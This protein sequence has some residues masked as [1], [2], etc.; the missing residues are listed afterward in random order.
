MKKSRVRCTCLVAT[1][2]LILFALPAVAKEGKGG[3]AVVGKNRS[4]ST[5]FV[6]CGN[7]LQSKEQFLA[8]LGPLEQCC[9][10]CLNVC[11]VSACTAT[12]GSRTIYCFDLEN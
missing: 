2:L 12:D 8:S 5:C 4:E 11:Q 9:E 1:A 6:D 7:S 3:T 10:L